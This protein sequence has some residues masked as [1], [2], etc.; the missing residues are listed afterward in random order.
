MTPPPDTLRALVDRLVPADDHPGG[1]AAGIREFLP[2]AL[3]GHARADAPLVDAGLA[4]LDAE[5]AARHG[6]AG[7]AALPPEAADAVIA[8]LLEDRPAA[9]W[10]EVAPAAFLRAVIRL[11][12]QGYYGDPGN[13]GNTGGATWRAIGYRPGPEDEPEPDRTPPP[14]IAWAATRDRYDAVVVGSGAGGG[15]AACVL[16]EAGLTVLLVE[17]GPWLTAADLRPDHLRNQRMVLAVNGGL[18][19]PAGPPAAGNPRVIA[20]PAGDE[21]V[22]PADPRWSNNA[23]TAGGGTRVFGAQA[24]RFCPEDFT[25]ATTYG[26]P[27]GSSL[28]DWPLTYDDLEPEY[29][30]AEWEIGVSGDPAGNAFA[31][32]RTRGYPMPPVRPNGTARVLARGA[33]ELGLRTSPVPLLVNSVPRDGR[34]GCVNCGACVGFGCPGEFKNGTHNT[35]IPRA[36]ATGRCDVLTGAQAERVVTGGPGGRVTGVALVAERDGRTVRRE[37]VAGHVV[38]AAGAVETARLLLNSASEREPRG[39]GNNLDQ[40]GRNLQGH[41]YAGAHALFDE[42]V[43]DCVGPGPSISTNDYRH[44]NAGVVGGGMLAND[45]VPTPTQVYATLTG[46]GVLPAWGAAAKAGMRE[47]YPRLALVAGPVQEIPSPAARVT[48]DPG[49]RDR[50]G[51]P[52][53]RLGGSPHPEDG[54]TAAFLAERAAAWLTAGGARSVFGFG[55]VATG[56]PSGGQHQ[57]GT[58]RMGSDPAASVTDPWGTVWGHDNVHIADASLHVTNGGVNPVLTILALAYRVAGHIARS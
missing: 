7:F 28:A 13:G 39:L 31:G 56:V 23:M 4:R 47:L 2:G 26:V 30:R 8:D 20:G 6:A 57:A 54:R 36:V 25:M 33:R 29:D 3:A 44:H 43:Q 52:V 46:L 19:T 16:A 27:E 49:T 24:W 14:T 38:L 17:R 50:F 21:V 51:V 11:C 5:A 15:V 22:W 34:G 1:W 32:R 45:F 10:G 48:V 58:C 9:D 40:V 37:V 41:L 35:V 55:T 53:A 42:A 12:A 18:D